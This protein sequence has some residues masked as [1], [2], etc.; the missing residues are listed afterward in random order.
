MAT[1]LQSDPY[2]VAV[3]LLPS[4]GRRDKPCELAFVSSY[5]DG[6]DYRAAYGRGQRVSV[7]WPRRDR[8]LYAVSVYSYGCMAPELQSQLLDEIRAC[9]E[10]SEFMR[11]AFPDLPPGD[12]CGMRPTG[13]D[14]DREIPGRYLVRWRH[15]AAQELAGPVGAAEAYTAAHRAV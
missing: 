15:A 13:L 10:S 9:V 6:V 3:S 5:Q 14:A 8:G 11:A 1:Q 2:R 4:L 12:F 7:Q